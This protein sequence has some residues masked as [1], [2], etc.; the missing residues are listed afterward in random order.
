MEEIL[1]TFSGF[2][3]TVF[4]FL[5][6]HNRFFMATTQANRPKITIQALAPY[7]F[8]TPL[9][10]LIARKN[11]KSLPVPERLVM[12]YV[13]DFPLE[14]WTEENIKRAFAIGGEIV[15]IDPAC[16]VP[17]YFGPIKL[18]LEVN[19]YLDIPIE[20]WISEK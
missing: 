20:I 12:A 10:C 1:A 19:H 2:H 18:I 4:T 8:R 9:S 3:Q 15:E 13:I 16:L 14:Q 17:K 5:T 7:I 11:L 6:A